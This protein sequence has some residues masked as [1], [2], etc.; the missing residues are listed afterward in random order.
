MQLKIYHDHTDSEIAFSSFEKENVLARLHAVD[1]QA[2]TKGLAT[3]DAETEPLVALGM[4]QSANGSVTK[5][6]L[7]VFHLS[8]LAETNPEWPAKIDS[9]IAAIRERI[10]KTHGVPLKFLI[11]AGMGGS[12]EDKALYEKAGLLRKGPKLYVLDSTDPA[13]LK[14]ILAEISDKS[15]LGIKDILKSTLIVAMALGMT[16]YEPVVNL[17][18]LAALY[19]KHKVD[20]KPNFLY[21]TLPGSI[22]DQFAGPRGF[23]RVPLQLDEG[24]S[25]SGR[26]SSPLTRGSLYPLALAKVDIKAWMAGTFLAEEDIQTA[27][28]LS[29]FLDAQGK[30]GR[31]KVTLLLS[32]PFAAAGI[33]TKQNFEESLGK[34]EQLGLKMVVDEKPKLSNYR[35]PKDAMQDRVFLAVI[36]KGADDGISEKAA[37]LRRSGY[38]VA[39]L[40]FDKTA[41]LSSYMQMMHYVVFGLGYLRKMNFVT[42][43]SVELYKAI[44]SRVH[45]DKTHSDWNGMMANPKQMKW[46][47]GVTLYYDKL[48]SVEVSGKTA[49][50]IY[51][52]ILKSLFLNGRMKYGELSFFGDSRYSTQGRSLR[53]AMDKAG[54]SVFR[55][56]LK[57]PVDVYEGP[58]MNHSF[59]EMII[60]H[61]KCF[62]T[63]IL[64]EKAEKLAGVDYSP[65]YHR[66]QFL[67]TQMALAERGRDVSAIILKDLEP[68]TI[69]A[70][71]DF[72]AQVLVELKSF[73]PLKCYHR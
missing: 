26:H 61:G 23:T 49:P 43:P 39:T 45:S 8:W 67:A 51:A 3:L 63:V 73:D 11:W 47:G 71:A 48:T 13:K 37:Q 12:A 10:Q 35:S 1:S 69:Q 44:T 53:K 25:T 6:S 28:R 68:Q 65:E 32:K 4:E 7:G 57:L 27:W 60:G 24:N 70:L 22:L 30:A 66:A 59:H 40:T 41:I 18:I 17:Q 62:S 36:V 19:D 2:R 56:K 29:S 20:A 34:S 46:R 9:E 21:M 72:F 58:A 5:N 14:N 38:P 52:S 64:S 42:Q 50:A 15:G 54:E 33:W 16:S 55:A 31:D